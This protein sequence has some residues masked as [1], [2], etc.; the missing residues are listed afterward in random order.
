VLDRAQ[1][2]GTAHRLQEKLSR[3]KVTAGQAWAF[4]INAS[5]GIAFAARA[6]SPDVSSLLKRADGLLYRAKLAGRNRIEVET[7]QASA[8]EQGGRP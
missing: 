7:G 5:F 2:V 1:A 4:T 3:A 6:D 8:T